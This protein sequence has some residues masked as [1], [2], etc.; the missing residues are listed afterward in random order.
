MKIQCQPLLHPCPRLEDFEAALPMM[1]RRPFQA[2]I[3]LF[4]PSIDFV[5]KFPA[6]E[7][8]LTNIPR[9]VSFSSTTS[10]A[11]SIDSKVIRS[12]QLAPWK[13]CES[14]YSSLGS[15]TGSYSQQGVLILS[16]TGFS[17]G[18]TKS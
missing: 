6:A 15:A 1:R 13:T 9:V 2:W 5:N 12:R 18:N 11:C 3:L 17:S 8:L 16:F 7:T 4:T 14:L 10:S